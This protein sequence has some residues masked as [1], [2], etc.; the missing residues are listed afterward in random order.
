MIMNLYLMH[1]FSLGDVD[2]VSQKSTVSFYDDF[3]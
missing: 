2:F 3:E 1:Y